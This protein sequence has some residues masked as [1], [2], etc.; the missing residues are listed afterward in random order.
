MGA[1]LAALVLWLL[2]HM[3]ALAIGSLRSRQL[4]PQP[5]SLLSAAR[6]QV[7]RYWRNRW[8][9]TQALREQA[10]ERRHHRTNI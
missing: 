4:L 6:E 3:V 1:G 9:R 10:I 7:F 5:G 8:C 2:R